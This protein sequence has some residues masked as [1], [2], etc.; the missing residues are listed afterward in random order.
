MSD[1]D[2]DDFDDGS[3]IASDDSSDDL[4]DGLSDHADDFSADV[5]EAIN[6]PIELSLDFYAQEGLDTY[7]DNEY[8]NTAS[9]QSSHS[10]IADDIYPF[11]L[12]IF[13]RR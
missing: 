5:K 9:S 2:G 11:G 1:V 6:N 4:D 10:N 7:R 3:T 8:L 13:K 12:S